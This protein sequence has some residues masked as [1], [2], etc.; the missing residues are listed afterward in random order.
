MLG[1]ERRERR[2]R[3][4]PERQDQPRARAQ[5]SGRGVPRAP[6]PAERRWSSEDSSGEFRVSKFSA[7]RTWSLSW[8]G[9]RV[10]LSQDIPAPL[11]RSGGSLGA[12][13]PPIQGPEPSDAQAAILGS[14]S[15]R[16][17]DQGWNG[18]GAAPP[19]GLL[20]QYLRLFAGYPMEVVERGRILYPYCCRQDLLCRDSV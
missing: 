13:A 5:W 4:S 17:I 1:V 14:G 6:F 3:N 19:L 10:K 2:E 7:E 12:A 16:A 8:P 20:G 11:T 15:G 9:V 18:G